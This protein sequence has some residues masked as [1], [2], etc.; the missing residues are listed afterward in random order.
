MATLILVIQIALTVLIMVIAAY[1]Q[2]MMC[3]ILLVMIQCA[4]ILTVVNMSVTRQDAGES[5]HY[6]GFGKNRSF[7]VRVIYTFP[8]DCKFFGR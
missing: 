1:A 2:I 6:P 4:A 8:C 5:P 7:R 3:A